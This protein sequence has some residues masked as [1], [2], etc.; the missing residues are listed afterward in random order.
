MRRE[1]ELI[2]RI[3]LDV[4]DSNES[5]NAAHWEDENNSHKKV[6]YHI[7]LVKEAGYLAASFLR[8]DG[9][10]YYAVQVSQLT[11]AGQDLADSLRTESVWNEVKKRLAKAGVDVTIDLLK[12]LAIKIAA[13]KLG[14]SA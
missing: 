4:A 6:G 5:L 2:R 1:S 3:V 14:I 7:W 9:D 8:A 12:A 13:E 11:W 10:P